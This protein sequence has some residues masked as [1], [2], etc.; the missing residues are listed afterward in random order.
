MCII[1]L[2]HIQCT[3]NTG[4]KNRNQRH[5]V[6]TMTHKPPRAACMFWVLTKLRVRKEKH[7]E[8]NKQN[9]KH[10]PPH[11]PANHKELRSWAAH[12]DGGKLCRKGWAAAREGRDTHSK[13]WSCREKS[14][15][16]LQEKRSGIRKKTDRQTDW[17]LHHWL[18]IWIG[19]W[20]TEDDHQGHDSGKEFHLFS[21]H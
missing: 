16:E 14:E 21:S 5:E 7:W 15:E 6:K 2:Q 8:Q 20:V 18:K 11:P 3:S 17:L 10:N 1:T 9:P 4:N 19:T 13:P 12:N